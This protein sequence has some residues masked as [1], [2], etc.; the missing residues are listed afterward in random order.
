MKPRHYRASFLQACA[1]VTLKIG[2]CASSWAEELWDR[3]GDDY[4]LRNTPYL[5]TIY[6]V[7]LIQLDDELAIF[8]KSW[9]VFLPSGAA[10]LRLL[11]AL[12]PSM[13]SLS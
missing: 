6:R 12:L 1:D 4:V 2:G 11:H 5:E 7:Q 8:L 13:D 10:E 9:L 3:N